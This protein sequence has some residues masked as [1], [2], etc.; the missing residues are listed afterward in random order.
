MLD[1]EAW[2][3]F[4]EKFERQRTFDILDKFEESLVDSEEDAK[5]AIH[6]IRKLIE[7]D[8]RD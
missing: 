5:M 3:E 2:F 6:I 8:G 1:Q 4:G 7:T